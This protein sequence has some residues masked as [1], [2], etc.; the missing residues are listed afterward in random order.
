MLASTLACVGVCSDPG[1]ERISGYGFTVSVSGVCK[2]HTSR[3]RAGDS[4]VIMWVI[5]WLVCTV[6]RAAVFSET[7]ICMSN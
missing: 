5:L 4:W 7:A 2:V 6:Y 3:P 1:E